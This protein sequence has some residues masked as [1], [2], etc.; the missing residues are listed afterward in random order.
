MP[1]LSFQKLSLKYWFA[2]TKSRLCQSGNKHVSK[3]VWHG[4]LMHFWLEIYLFCFHSYIAS[5]A[6]QQSS[7]SSHKTTVLLHQCPTES[8][9]GTLLVVFLADLLCKKCIFLQH[10]IQC[11]WNV[12]RGVQ[13]SNTYRAFDFSGQILPKV[14]SYMQMGFRTVRPKMVPRRSVSSASSSM[15]VAADVPRRIVSSFSSPLSV[16]FE[17]K[18]PTIPSLLPCLEV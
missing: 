6:M 7:N 17:G 4:R 13:Y 10:Q 2:S 5:Q 11:G 9:I 8:G 18:F 3:Q 1:G 12:R 14:A 15:A 16:A